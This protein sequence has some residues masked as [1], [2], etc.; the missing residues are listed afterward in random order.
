MRMLRAVTFSIVSKTPSVKEFVS[1]VKNEC[2]VGR[3]TV[4]ADATDG[5]SKAGIE[6]AVFN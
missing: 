6:I 2:G 4:L 3:L 5:D 1:Y